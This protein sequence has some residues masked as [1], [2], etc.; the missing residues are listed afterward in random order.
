MVLSDFFWL[1]VKR[2]SVLRINPN[3]AVP[4]AVSEA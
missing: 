1:E 3:M 2:D 4:F